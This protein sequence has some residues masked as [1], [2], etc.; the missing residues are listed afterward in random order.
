MG[1]SHLCF[2]ILPVLCLLFLTHYSKGA[3]LSWRVMLSVGKSS[4]NQA[5]VQQAKTFEESD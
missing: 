3:I 2:L 4:F 1:T 5:H